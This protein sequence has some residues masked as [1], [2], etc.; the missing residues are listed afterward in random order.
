MSVFETV[1]PLIASTLAP[2][3]CPGVDAPSWL[4]NSL[5]VLGCVPYALLVLYWIKSVKCEQVVSVSAW[6]SAAGIAVVVAW[7]VGTGQHKKEWRNM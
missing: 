7:W 3:R 5:A 6:S 1:P 4:T 2:Q